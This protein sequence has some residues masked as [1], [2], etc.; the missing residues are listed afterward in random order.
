M[1]VATTGPGADRTYGTPIAV[2]LPERGAMNAMTVSSHDANKSGPRPADCRMLPSSRPV[3]AALI[4]RSLASASEARSRAADLADGPRVSGRMPGLR[5]SAATGSPGRALRR[6]TARH[7]TAATMAAAIPSAAAT[8]ATTGVGVPGH[9]RLVRP[10]TRS[11]AHRQENAGTRPPASPAAARA[12]AHVSPATANSPQHSARTLHMPAA[13]P[14]DSGTRGPVA[15][16]TARP[17]PARGGS[18][19]RCHTAGARLRRGSVRPGC[20][21]VPRS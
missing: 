17:C 6:A 9:A 11:P 4:V 12:A 7:T 10:V 21:A 16:F 18:P 14:A 5:R 19:D 2:V 15:R 20:P 1:L 8:A 13:F 3:S